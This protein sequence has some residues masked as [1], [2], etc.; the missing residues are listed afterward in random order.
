MRAETKMILVTGAT[1]TAGRTVIDALRNM[2]A[3]LRGMVRNN[4]GAHEVAADF[5]DKASLKT[6]LAGVDTV[7]VVCSPIPQ[8][9]ELEGNMIE[10]CVG[11]GVGHV[12]QLSALGAG[13]YEKSFPSWHRKVEDKLRTS[14]VGYTILRPNGFYQ[15]IGAFYAPTVRTQGAFYAAMADAKSSFLDVRD[16]GSA[17][18]AILASPSAHVGMTYELNGPE[19]LSYSEI[20]ERISRTVG[21]LVKYVDIPEDA[22]RK[23]MLE[24]GMPSWQVEALLELQQYYVSGKAGDVTDVLP[25]LLG[26]PPITLDEYLSENKDSFTATV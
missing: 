17:A 18:A 10:A 3:P 1:G 24:L 16:V 15:N 9:V 22:Q 5:T 13:D 14:G 20:A 26:R 6:A 7:F 21:R 4:P 8:L 25:S 2:G 11:A 23:S 19:A 12:V